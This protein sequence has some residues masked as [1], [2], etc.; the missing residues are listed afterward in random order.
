MIFKDTHCRQRVLKRKALL[1]LP[2]NTQRLPNQIS[3]HGLNKFPQEFSDIPGGIFSNSGRN[4]LIFSL[5][6]LK[7]PHRIYFQPTQNLI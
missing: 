3:H 6:Y 4:F 7:I 2:L 1:V 5:E